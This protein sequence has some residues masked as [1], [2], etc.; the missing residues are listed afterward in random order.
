MSHKC[1]KLRHLLIEIAR[2]EILN[3]AGFFLCL[4]DEFFHHGGAQKTE[5]YGALQAAWKSEYEPG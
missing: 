4:E 3:F 5:F 1:L 2:D